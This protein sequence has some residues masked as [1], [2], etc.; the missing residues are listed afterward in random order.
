MSRMEAA[1]LVYLADRYEASIFLE[2]GDKL[3]NVKSTLGLLSLL[4]DAPAE[5]TLTVSGTD[6]NAA[7]EAVCGMFA[8]WAE[9][10]RNEGTEELTEREAEE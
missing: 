6:E 4:A 10:N 2:G 1:K 3:V 9:R 8:E 7:A 5:M